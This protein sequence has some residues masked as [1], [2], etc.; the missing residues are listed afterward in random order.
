MEKQMNQ[1]PNMGY[2]SEIHYYRKT[3]RLPFEEMD[4]DLY[5]PKDISRIIGTLYKDLCY[6][7]QYAIKI[8]RFSDD[9]RTVSRGLEG[10]L[11]KMGSLLIT[12][13]VFEQQG[14]QIP[15][16]E[17]LTLSRL[18]LTANYHFNKAHAAITAI[19][20]QNPKL[21]LALVAQEIRW[22]TLLE[23]LDATEQ[24]IQDIREGKTVI[25]KKDKKAAKPA[26]KSGKDISSVSVNASGPS[27]LPIVNELLPDDSRKKETD[28]RKSIISVLAEPISEET[29]EI[30]RSVM[31]EMT[32]PNGGAADTEKKDIGTPETVS[33]D[34]SEKMMRDTLMGAAVITG[35]RELYEMI[36]AAG[37]PELRSVWDDFIRF[38]SQNG[39]PVLTAM[40]EAAEGRYD[41][42]P[43]ENEPIQL[44]KVWIPE[45]TYCV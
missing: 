41:P 30:F 18:Y 36:A 42:P 29:E 28:T 45:P 16:P 35:N 31:E 24:K 40:Q 17:D 32:E 39:Y 1:N 34:V 3:D 25:R 11:R 22:A 43:D 8:N 6:M 38:E 27:A 7:E 19:H 9:Y 14:Y 23:R 26:D 10:V 12:K 5:T 37:S 15:V 2:K 33:G 13:A 20:L 4:P 44:D 21:Y